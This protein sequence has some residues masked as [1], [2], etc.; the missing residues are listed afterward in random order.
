MLAVEKRAAPRCFS[1]STRASAYRSSILPVFFFYT[2]LPPAFLVL[3]N[4]ESQALVLRP[5]IC[6]GSHLPRRK[7][8]VETFLEV[9]DQCRESNRTCNLSLETAST[10]LCTS[11][12]EAQTANLTTRPSRRSNL[13]ICH[14]FFV[15]KIACS[16]LLWDTVL[17]AS[18]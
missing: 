1:G 7:E 2:S 16:S 10:W 17:T 5:D 12:R 15:D 13:S 8:T 14:V 6:F 4:F 18:S 9:A 11:A 3:R